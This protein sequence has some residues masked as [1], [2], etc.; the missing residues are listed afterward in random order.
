[1][2]VINIIQSNDNF[3]RYKMEKLESKNE[4]NK[5]YLVNLDKVSR[6]LKTRDI[7]IVKNYEYQL[8]TRTSYDKKRHQYYLCGLYNNDKLMVLL[9]DFIKKYLIC[10]VCNLPEITFI[11]EAELY[12]KCSACG[13]KT[14]SYDCKLSK[15][16]I[17]NSTD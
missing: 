16:I 8:G 9:N 4:V 6:N 3:N 2:V 5:T 14:K 11:V 15:Y 10:K 17:K 13:I 7:Y 12:F 1:M